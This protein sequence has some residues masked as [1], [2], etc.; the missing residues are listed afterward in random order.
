MTSYTN[1]SALKHI[2]QWKSSICLCANKSFQQEQSFFYQN[3]IIELQSIDFEV[4][5]LPPHVPAFSLP[6]P[7]NS[8]SLIYHSLHVIKEGVSLFNLCARG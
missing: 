7:S 3:V 8:L 1:T 2:Y 4:F 5:L 6:P